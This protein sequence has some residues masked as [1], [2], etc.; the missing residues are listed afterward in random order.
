[1]EPTLRRL[2]K[3]GDRS[4]GVLLHPT[5]LP[6]PA[7]CG[8][9]GPSAR[10]FA[11]FLHAAGQRWW[12][13]LPVEPLGGG[14]SPY[15]TVSAFA[16]N[17]L[18]ISTEALAKEG[19]IDS[20]KR[21]GHQRDARSSEKVDYAKAQRFSRAC[22][23]QAWDRFQKGAP[24]NTCASLKQ[25]ERRQA[26]WLEDFALFCVLREEQSGAAWHTWPKPIRFRDRSALDRIRSK[27]ARRLGYHRFVQFLFARQWE[28]LRRTC[29]RL[30]LGLIG[31]M[32]FFLAQD[33]ADVW[34]HPDLFG[35][36]AQGRPTQLAGVPPD[37]FSRNGQ[38]WGNPLYRWRRHQE[39]GFAWW[40]ARLKH[41]LSRFDAVRLDH[42]I[43]F[44]RCWAVKPSSKTA[45]AGKFVPSPGKQLFE[46]AQASLGD[47][48]VIAEDLGVVTPEVTALRGYLGFPGMRVL[49]FAF[50][51]PI[52]TNEH[53]PHNYERSCVVYPG[54]HDNDT[55]IGWFKSLSRP[56][57]GK[58]SANLKLERRALKEYLGSDGR[59]INW[60]LIR[61][62]L[63]SIAALSVIPMQDLIGLDSRS[64]MNYPGTVKGNWVW[65]MRASA[66]DK[67]LAERLMSMTILAGR[68]AKGNK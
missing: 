13:M 12:Q 57:L 54:T 52:G 53:L 3:L 61:A 16:G 17:P 11:M 45:R 58:K 66:M 68:L 6:G 5:S 33:S 31:D 36:D 7:P 60:D 50:S 4:S 41:T 32:P 64:R 19:L 34:A 63:T 18:L 2:P 40:V 1:M 39:T 22:L 65:R 47:L 24:P 67:H 43:G 10:R 38:L 14:A 25:F 37:Y 30:G 48:A 56:G 42:F 51:D 44:H 59:A 8:D 15:Q 46:R 26:V 49:Q 21:G 62:A 20:L 28:S 23:E 35:L 27:H 9:I 29:G 55:A